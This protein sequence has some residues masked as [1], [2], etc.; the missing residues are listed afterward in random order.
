MYIY[1][2]ICLEIMIVEMTKMVLELW[3]SHSSQSQSVVEDVGGGVVLVGHE[4]F[5]A[6]VSLQV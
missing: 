5:G 2:T 4:T 1:R 6:Q 3:K